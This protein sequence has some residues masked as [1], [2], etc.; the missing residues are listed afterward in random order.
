MASSCSELFLESQI[1]R[2]FTEKILVVDVRAPIEYQQGSLAGSVNLPILTN[3]EREIV[4]TAYKNQGPELATDLGHQLVSGS[5]KEER[6]KRWCETLSQ[7]S[8]SVLMC[9]RGGQ[10]SQISQRWCKDAGVARPRVEGGY[11]AVRA[12]AMQALQETSQR[13][14]MIAI[15]G[16]TGSGKSLLIQ[17]LK[18]KIKTLDLEAYANHRGSA[19]G[20]YPEG[21]PSQ[22]SFENQ[23]VQQILIQEK[24]QEKQAGPEPFMV[25]DESRM[26]G[27]IVVPEAFFDRM[28]S[29]PVVLVHESLASRTDVTFRDYIGGSRLGDPTAE[30]TEGLK[31]FA[32]YEHSL[33]KISKKLGGLRYAEVLRDLH[34]SQSQYL[35]DRSLDSNRVWI[36]KLLEWYYD[37]LYLKSFE[38]RAPRVLFEGSRAEV[39]EFLL[40]KPR[41]EL[42]K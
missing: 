13:I 28:R 8:S 31:V 10:R 41:H 5:I 11:K 1:P 15:T 29:F 35:R 32:R 14:K 6:V 24:Q 37:P 22:A 34:F 27:Q 38:K 33:F 30:E 12:F 40:S 19:F 18:N 36:S 17:A 3:K 9:F 4:G 21:Q 23:L 16:K 7:E 39:E 25:E 2:L 20:G 26:I 42:L